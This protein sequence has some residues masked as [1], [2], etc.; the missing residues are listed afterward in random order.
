MFTSIEDTMREFGMKKVLDIGEVPGE[1]AFFMDSN[2]GSARLPLYPVIKKQMNL[3]HNLLNLYG[4]H[5]RY[6]V[7]FD[8]WEQLTKHDGDLKR[9]L[10]DIEKGEKSHRHANYAFTQKYVKK[11][12]KLWVFAP[13]TLGW[14]L[15]NDVYMPRF[16]NDMDNYRLMKKEA[17]K[18]R[19]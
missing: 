19:L 17:R 4:V 9:V 5:W 11:Q 8:N 7:Q 15:H 16:K 13:K 14:E 12:G 18:S 6:M 10:E 1:G 2:N 3:A